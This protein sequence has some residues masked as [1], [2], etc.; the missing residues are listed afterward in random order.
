MDIRKKNIPE[1]YGNEGRYRETHLDDKG[2]NSLLKSLAKCKINYWG[3]KY[4]D[5]FIMDGFQWEI[6][7]KF[8]GRRAFKSCGDNL[9][10]PYLVELEKL[11]FSKLGISPVL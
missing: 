1:I 4:V 3:K 8:E 11:V 5:E 2:L 7:M 9:L 6:E 10:P